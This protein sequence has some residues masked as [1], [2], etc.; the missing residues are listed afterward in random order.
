MKQF[1]DAL[2]QAMDQKSSYGALLIALTLP[3]ICRKL[4]DPILSASKGYPE[5]LDK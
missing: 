1:V 2:R 3:D 4:V 5:W